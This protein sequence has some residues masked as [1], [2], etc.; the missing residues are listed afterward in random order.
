[1]LQVFEREGRLLLLVMPSNPTTKL[2]AHGLLKSPF[3]HNSFELLMT[4]N[5]PVID[6]MQ[7]LHKVSKMKH[8][9]SFQ[10]IHVAADI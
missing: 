4:W 2:G 8:E 7:S 9:A 5:V 10:W 3:L 6:S 1:M